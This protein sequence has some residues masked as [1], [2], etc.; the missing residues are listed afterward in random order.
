MIIIR[1]ETPADTTAVYT[2]NKLA[3]DGRDAEPGLVDA[4]RKSDDFIPELSLVAEESG[5]IVGHILFSPITIQ[6]E[7]GAIPAISLAPLAVLPP[8]QRQ[9]IGAKLVLKGLEECKRL[10]HA[11]VIVLGHPTYYP[12]FGFS[13][14]LAKSLAC[15]FGDCGD[16][17]MALELIPG[18]LSGLTG[19]VVYPSVFDGV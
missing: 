8:Y 10:G 5:Q 2:V 1:S 16:A 7:N 4:I 13:A 6:T 12:R 3:F 17:W 18:A 15:P 9:G 14:A 11:I 19:K